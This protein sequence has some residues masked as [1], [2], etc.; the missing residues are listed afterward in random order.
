MSISSRRRPNRRRL[1]EGA[2]AGSVLA[3]LLTGGRYVLQLRDTKPEIQDPGVW[4]LFGGRIERGEAPRGALVR[5]IEEELG[6]H[7]ADCRFLGR[8]KRDSGGAAPRHPYW[9]F[10]ADISPFWGRHRL[11]EGQAVNCFSFEEL[12][13]LT[14]PPFI[15]ELLERHYFEKIPKRVQPVRL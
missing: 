11:A 10:E 4:A 3:V 6:I 7:L 9:V 1:R 5:E 15:R 2:E 8:L 12:E 14:I 13:G